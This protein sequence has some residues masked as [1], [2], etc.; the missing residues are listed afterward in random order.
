MSITQQGETAVDRVAA[1]DDGLRWLALLIREGF[2]VIVAGIERRFGMQ[3]RHAW[4]RC[5]WRG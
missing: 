2:L 1:E 3:R 5:G 4:P